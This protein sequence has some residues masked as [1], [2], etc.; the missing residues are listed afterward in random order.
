ME[1]KIPLKLKDFEVISDNTNKEEVIND[2]KEI[3]DFIYEEEKILFNSDKEYKQ[4]CDYISNNKKQ[5]S[6]SMGRYMGLKTSVDYSYQNYN[7]NEV[8]RSISIDKS[9]GYIQSD[10]LFT[11]LKETKLTNAKEI[12]KLYKEKY[13]TKAPTTHVINTHLH[14]FY[15]KEETKA[16]KPSP[17]K[18]F[19]LSQTDMHFCSKPE[20]IDNNI[21]ITVKLSKGKTTLKFRIPND[22]RFTNNVTKYS[23]PNV[24]IQ[25]D[26]LVFVFTVFKDVEEK[27]YKNIMGVDIGKIESFVATVVFV[28]DK[29]YSAPYFS[30]KNINVLTKRIKNLFEEINRLDRK[31]EI[32]ERCNHPEKVEVLKEERRR[33]RNKISILKEQRAS[34]QANTIVKIADENKS[35][36]VLE[37]LSWVDKGGTWE[38]A[39]VHEKIENLAKANGIE[40]SKVS[41]RDTSN[42]CPKC[43]K[44][45][46]HNSKTRK[47][48]CKNCNKKLDRDVLA[49]R[50]IAKRKNKEVFKE[51]L[52]QKENRAARIRESYAGFL[53]NE[54]KLED[55]PVENLLKCNQNYNTTC[56]NCSFDK[57]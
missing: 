27:E 51:L 31:I 1:V 50:N 21:Y 13:I 26:K 25:N 4:V 7:I 49:S 37:E 43:D 55:K 41:A 39:I 8:F 2:L 17:A 16:T 40:V 56:S 22:E 52:K 23:R 18:E 5:N 44:K 42:N 54:K 48:T 12:R 24:I 20:I 30:T 6:N 11:I 32:N 47:T 10:N 46:S 57:S 15:N 45:V 35:N 28:D 33:K 38:R 29:E 36:I 19:P 53:F 3:L 9:Y 34:L 14:R